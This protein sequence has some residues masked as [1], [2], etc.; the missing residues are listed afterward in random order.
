MGKQFPNEQLCSQKIKDKN[1]RLKRMYKQFTE[2]VNHTGIGW[3]VDTNTINESPDVRDMFINKNRVFKTFRNKDCKHYRLLNELFNSS[4]ATGALRIS[5][6]DLPRTSDEEQQLHEE[7]ISTSKKKQKQPV[8][9]QEGPD[10]SD[11]PVQ[12][13]E[14]IIF[15]SRHRVRKRP[16]SKSSKLQECMDLFKASFKQK[17]HSTPPSSKRNKS[18]SSPEKNSIWEAMVELDKLKPTI[19]HRLYIA[20]SLTLLDDKMMRL[21]MYY[22]E[23]G[24]R[25]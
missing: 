12:I 10:E 24:Q 8:N 19:P 14:P 15:E 3:D 7:F 16:S 20:G 5:S 21:F 18:V 9:L 25:K 1:T 13:Q 23:D 17:P 11:D 2:M 4:S 22:T 6:I